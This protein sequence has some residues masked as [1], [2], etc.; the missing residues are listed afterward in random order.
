MSTP[1]HPARPKGAV[2]GRA[3]ER[4]EEEAGGR[5]VVRMTVRISG[6]RGKREEEVVQVVT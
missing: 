4:G 2:D 3:A 1:A 6:K 5:G